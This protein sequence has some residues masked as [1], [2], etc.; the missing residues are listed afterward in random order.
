MIDVYGVD[1]NTWSPV[2]YPAG[3]KAVLSR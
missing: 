3:W 2:D 1:A